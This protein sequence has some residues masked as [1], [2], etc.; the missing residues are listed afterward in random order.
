MDLV[1]EV[2]QRSWFLVTMAWKKLSLSHYHI[3]STLGKR[4]DD[5]P[6]P[7][8]ELIENRSTLLKR[9]VYQKRDSWNITGKDGEKNI[10]WICKQFTNAT[11][12]I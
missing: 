7:F 10:S 6:L 11:L 9:Q 3:S 12:P 4:N 8:I 5:Y 2:A 1:D